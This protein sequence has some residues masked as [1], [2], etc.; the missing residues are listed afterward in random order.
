MSKRNA[1]WS[2]SDENERVKQNIAGAGKTRCG[3]SKAISL[4]ENQR[5]G[6]H[7][8]PSVPAF[9]GHF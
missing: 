5:L 4:S 1:S 3:S 2:N 8:R 7:K 9:Y 6:R